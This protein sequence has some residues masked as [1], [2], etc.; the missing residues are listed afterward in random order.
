MDTKS[1]VEVL[2]NRVSQVLEKYKVLKDE[3]ERLNKEV[4]RLSEENSMKDLEIED[5]ITKVEN[6]LN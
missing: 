4:E 5:I 2:D 3:N 1:S 6:I